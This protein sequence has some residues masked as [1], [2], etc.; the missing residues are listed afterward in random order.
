MPLF[1]FECHACG[2]VFE[3]LVAR[4]D[5]PVPCPA[6]DSADVERLFSRIAAG[7]K[8]GLTGADARR[9]NA[10]RRVREE[11]RWDGFRVQRERLGL[12]PRKSG[13]GDQAHPR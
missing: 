5:A 13:P 6:C 12:P 9:S 10:D 7:R 1:D 11:R 4:A 8:V 2:T 3:D